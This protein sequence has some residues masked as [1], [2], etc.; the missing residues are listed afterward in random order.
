[1]PEIDKVEI[2]KALKEID[3][4]KIRADVEK[5]L[6]SVDVAKIQ[7]EV[8]ASLAK[9]DM[10]AM[11]KEIEASMKELKLSMANQKEAHAKLAEEMKN[12][13][14]KIE[15]EMKKARADIEKARKELDTYEA[16][17]TSLANDGLLNKTAY[18]IE[19]KDG[20]L[21][22]DGKEQ[23]EAVYNKHRSFLEKQKGLKIKKNE[24]GLNIH[25]D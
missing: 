2:E 5:S 8:D 17:V 18:T 22:I 6:K 4:E 24:D 11:R 14:P 3:V 16:F 7:K 15:A 21:Y 9:V 25:K 19:H 13:Q 23:P 10:A 12:M 1:M 20:K